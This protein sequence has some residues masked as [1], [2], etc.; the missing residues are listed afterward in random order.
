MESIKQ[1]L[2]NVDQAIKTARPETMD[3][4]ID[5]VH[6]VNGMQN[7]GSHFKIVKKVKTYTAFV[8]I[9]LADLK[10]MF[11]RLV[12]ILIRFLKVSKNT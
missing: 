10:I 5:T 9:Y 1:V 6:S 12:W 11:C 4:I 3:E 8:F 7:Y 2:K